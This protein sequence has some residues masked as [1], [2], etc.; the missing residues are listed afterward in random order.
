[1]NARAHLHVGRLGKRKLVREQ[2]SLGVNDGEI[3]NQ[4]VA[5]LNL[6]ETQVIPGCGDRLTQ[7]GDLGGQ[8]VQIG[9]RVF[10]VA[11]RDQHLIHIRR[12]A[13]PVQRFG[14]VE[15]RPEPAA[16]KDWGRQTFGNRPEAA[17]PIEQALDRAAFEAR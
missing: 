11:V 16:L 2:R 9:Q 15:I 8:G 13:L 4:A 12:D 17:P 3:V 7:A 1:M 5:K 6:R 14:R 10:D